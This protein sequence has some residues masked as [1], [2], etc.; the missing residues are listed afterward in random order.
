MALIAIRIKR[1]IDG[2]AGVPARRT[3][4]TPVPPSRELSLTTSD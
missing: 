3:A 2:A 4:E 1:F